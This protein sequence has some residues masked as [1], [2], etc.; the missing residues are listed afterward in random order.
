MEFI[1]ARQKDFTTY[2]ILPLEKTL[3]SFRKNDLNL[4]NSYLQI[5]E[6]RNEH[7]KMNSFNLYWNFHLFLCLNLQIYFNY[8]SCV[9]MFWMD[10]VNDLNNAPREQYMTFNMIPKISTRTIKSNK[11]SNSGKSIRK[12]R[13]RTRSWC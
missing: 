3:V 11:K 8:H 10:F 7:L 12:Q 5:S 13:L 1:V 9:S 2:L 6:Y 4:V